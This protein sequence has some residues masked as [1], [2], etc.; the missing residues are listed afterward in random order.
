[1]SP[2]KFFAGLDAGRGHY[3][4]QI[5]LAASAAIISAAP[6]DALYSRCFR[7]N[8]QEKEPRELPKAEA[9]GNNLGTC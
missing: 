8:A 1:V 4:N 9:R 6:R 7:Y 3:V 5:I 2:V